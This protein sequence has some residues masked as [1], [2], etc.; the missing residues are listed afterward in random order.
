MRVVA[1]ERL[2]QLRRRY[3][4]ATTPEATGR[5]A[6]VAPQVSAVLKSIPWDVALAARVMGSSDHLLVA[7][8]RSVPLAS[9]AKLL[10]AIHVL[11][12]VDRGIVSMDDRHLV[13]A[14][15]RAPG[16]TST[17]VEVGRRPTVR[18]LLSLSLQ[19][20]DN[21]APS[22]LLEIGG[23]TG[24]VSQTLAEAGVRGGALSRTIRE[25][26]ADYYG[27]GL[28]DGD[29]VFLSLWRAVHA[30]VPRARRYAA[31]REF[32]ADPRD[33]TT[34]AEMLA[35][36]DALWSQK[37][38]RSSSRT[39]LLD[40]LASTITGSERIV[41]GVPA[42]TRVEH[43]TGTLEGAL[44]ADVGFISLPSGERLG[45]AAYVTGHGASH[46]QS[47]CIARLTHV[48]WTAASSPAPVVRST[49][50]I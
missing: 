36:L 39:W 2:R 37:L 12:L 34:P 7:A 28:T 33:M 23:G 35:V 48:L 47:D 45:M 50:E 10:I 18:E 46:A 29:D 30:A 5:F 20:S 43:K 44:A 16:P 3:W 24:A 1:R 41:R 38:L 49:E 42:G 15:H 4:R 27:I 6:A 32:L 26:V 14:R 25:I 9:T 22:L 8:D 13:C 19:E 40:T 31:R 17:R 11:S 21:T